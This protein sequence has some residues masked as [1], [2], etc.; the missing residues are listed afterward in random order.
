MLHRSAQAPLRDPHLSPR[1]WHAV[2]EALRAIE[3]DSCAG[4]GRLRRFVPVLRR[5]QT[6]QR[7][8]ILRLREFLCENARHGPAVDTLAKKLQ[9]QGFSAA[10]VAALSLIAG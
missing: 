3:G 6:A 2:Q 4:I 1:E 10:Q 7:P 8:E 5:K 9:H